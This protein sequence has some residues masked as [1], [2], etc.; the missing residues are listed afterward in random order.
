MGLINAILL[1]YKQIMQIII[2]GGKLFC[3]I[4]NY[5]AIKNENNSI[6]FFSFG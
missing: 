5:L 1:Y 4:V 3:T 6:L 2:N